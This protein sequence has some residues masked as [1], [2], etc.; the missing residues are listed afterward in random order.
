M[1]DNVDKN[2]W[3]SEVTDVLDSDHLQIILHLLDHIRSRNL[4]DPVDRFT[5]W[6]R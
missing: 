1:H 2:V 5:D 3:L 4:L 6:E